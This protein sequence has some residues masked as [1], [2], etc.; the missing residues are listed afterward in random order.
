MKPIII[1]V[2]AIFISML[3]VHSS[4]SQVVQK[5]PDTE[6]KKKNNNLLNPSKVKSSS[7]LIKYG[8]VKLNSKTVFIPQDS[9]SKHKSSNINEIVL[10]KKK[11]ILNKNK[12]I[13]GKKDRKSQIREVRMVGSSSVVKKTINADY[14]RPN[15]MPI[16]SNKIRTPETN[17]E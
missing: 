17:E 8:S 5:Q 15:K 7:S 2:T 12:S 4:F 9:Q 14:V 11:N 16:R 3:C 1:A 13:K 10:P 6:F